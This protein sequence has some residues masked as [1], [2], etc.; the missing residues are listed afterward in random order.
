V[1]GRDGQFDQIHA[2]LQQACEGEPDGWTE[3]PRVFEVLRFQ[4][5]LTRRATTR[6]LRALLDQY[7]REERV[8]AH[9][10][11]GRR[12]FRPC[13]DQPATDAVRSA[14]RAA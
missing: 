3:P 13:A 8:D 1:T 5:H 11:R 6:R 12:Y 9:V 7:A 14:D 2:A 10:A 4:G